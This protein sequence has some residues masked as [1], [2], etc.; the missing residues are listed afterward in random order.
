MNSHKVSR[1]AA[2]VLALLV[3][4]VPLSAA[5]RRAVH[6]SPPAGQINAEVSGTVLD[7]VSGQPVASVK[8]VVGSKSGTTNSQG[9]YSIRN[10]QYIGS[11][12]TVEA[13]RS[14]YVGKSVILT[15]GGKQVV[16]FRLDPLAT[17]T[18]KLKDG[19]THQLD[20][21]SMR[22][23]YL[24]GLSDY[25]DDESED[26]CK[27]D[28]TKVEIDRLQMKKITGPAVAAASAPC[29]PQSTSLR[30]NLELKSGE[31]TDVFFVDSCQGYSSDIIAR[32]HVTGKFEYISFEDITELVFP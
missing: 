9:K 6:V 27:P 16:D 30:I 2:L 20:V 23:G 10:I 18:V 4:A 12:M 17:A 26:F 1:T 3:G 28:G 22:F 15:T 11:S 24:S 8:V 14:G 5:K 21:D 31:K 7:N 13:Q 32:D 19:T 25:I 29:C